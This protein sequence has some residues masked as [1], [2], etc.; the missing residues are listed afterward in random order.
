MSLEGSIMP[1][2][3]VRSTFAAERAA[4]RSVRGA[5]GLPVKGGGSTDEEMGFPF[6]RIQRFRNGGRVLVHRVL[7][8]AEHACAKTDE[9][10]RR[11]TAYGD[12]VTQFLF[13]LRVLHFVNLIACAR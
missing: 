10:V 11:S 4:R 6:F 9:I 3:P 7:D 5:R 1:C 13:E 8:R 12:L 2:A